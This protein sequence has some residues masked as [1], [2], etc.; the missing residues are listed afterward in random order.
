MYF[1]QFGIIIFYHHSLGFELLALF[2]SDSCQFKVV[3]LVGPLV[4]WDIGPK[5]FYGGYLGGYT[6][7]YIN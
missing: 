5:F 6:S 7:P 4:K 2:R 1:K 3:I